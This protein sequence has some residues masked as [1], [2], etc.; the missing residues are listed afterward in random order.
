MIE[1]ATK[2]A[3]ELGKLVL[4]KPRKN[5]TIN[6]TKELC[7]IIA[8]DV[9]Q[10]F[11]ANK[12]K[13]YLLRNKRPVS[14]YAE[15]IVVQDSIH[16]QCRIPEPPQPHFFSYGINVSIARHRFKREVIQSLQGVDVELSV[17]ERLAL[18]KIFLLR[19]SNSS[20]LAVLKNTEVNL[21]QDHKNELS[22]QEDN[23]LNDVISQLETVDKNTVKRYVN[24]HHL[25]LNESVAGD[26]VLSLLKGYLEGI[27]WNRMDEDM[28]TKSAVDPF[29]DAAFESGTALATP[30]HCSS[31]PGSSNNFKPPGICYS[32]C[33]FDLLIWEIKI[34]KSKINDTCK[35]AGEL[36]IMLQR[37]VQVGFQDPVVFRV[38]VQGFD[39]QVYKLVMPAPAVFLLQNIDGFSLPESLND[40]KLCKKILPALK[41]LES[42]AMKQVVS[43]AD[44]L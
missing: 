14:Y 34:P 21:I 36:K 35:L 2:C 16:R 7:E 32:A 5:S 23:F 27:N 1:S 11:D 19:G 8:K 17:M 13:G 3:K 25:S 4:S 33:N 40:L 22:E 31:L 12:K 44:S 6:A 41:H 10:H 38:V 37:L 24:G 15:E 29:F 39:C 9:N 42:E 20:E 43:L 30:G 18:D 28:F 26:V